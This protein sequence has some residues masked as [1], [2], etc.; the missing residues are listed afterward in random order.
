MS[1][2][3][4]IL[5]VEDDLSA[6]TLLRD[7]LNDEFELQIA[8][9]GQEALKKTEC[10]KP[11]IILLDIMMPGVDGYEVCRRV[12]EGPQGEEIKILLVTAKCMIEERLKGYEAGAD[13]Y[14]TKPF[15][16]LEMLA[17][18]QIF[19]RLVIAEKRRKQAE[20]SLIES[21]K[22]LEHTVD[23]RTRELL[24]TN[25]QL[26]EEI[27]R[28]KIASEEIIRSKAYLESSFESAPDGVLLL[29][30]DGKFTYVNPAFLNLVGRDLKD[31][32]G[33]T[34]EELKARFRN[35]DIMNELSTPLKRSLERD[36]HFS[37]EEIELLNSDGEVIPVAFSSSAIKDR[38]GQILGKIIF[39]KD[40]T[41]QKRMQDLMVQYEKMMSVG[42]LAA[43]MAHE[44]NNP[45]SAILQT[46]QN[47]I[48]RLSPD[49]EK[50]IAVAAKYDVDLQKVQ[51]FFEE[52]NIPSFIEAIRESGGRAAK[53]IETMLRFSRKSETKMAQYDLSLIVEQAL[54]LA[55][56][57]Y[58]LKKKYDFKNIKIIK[59]L[60]PDLPR[61]I[62]SETEIQQVVLNLLVNAA[63][64]MMETRE[65][66][67]PQ[68]TLRTR[69]EG[70]KIRLEVGDNGPGIKEEHRNKV[71][72]P[73]FTTKPIGLGT[74]LG[75]AVSYMII[76]NLHQGTMELR[77]GINEG[78]T[79][80]IHLPL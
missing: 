38:D 62:C 19:D 23:I 66:R 75:L 41:E 6:A 35:T 17:K 42:G 58:D 60:E 5:V 43:G 51:A 45:L 18:V 80:I 1:E 74:G 47:L 57:E 72:E 9:D 27:R 64:A 59:E 77:T 34:A 56:S 50:N 37:G 71:F 11:D 46:S 61:V 10:F 55:N 54:A 48:R 53:I 13:D 69:L 33:H 44:I 63:Q 68:I 22:T 21:H 79:F 30:Q 29:D 49:S 52:Q 20:K 24:E 40:V 26:N 67:S 4:K 36:P 2:K 32:I 73:F 28:H 78:T 25:E 8:Y 76:T 16:P 14:I 7:T 15:E 70:E 12:K 39:F 65:L 3:S 31:F